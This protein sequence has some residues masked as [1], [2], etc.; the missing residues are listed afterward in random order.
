MV[1][2]SSHAENEKG[3]R[4]RAGLFSYGGSAAPVNRRI[5][6]AEAGAKSLASAPRGDTCNP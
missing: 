5:R 3:R 2:P 1:G 4:P 6:A